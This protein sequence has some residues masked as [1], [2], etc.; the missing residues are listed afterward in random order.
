MGMLL[1][2]IVPPQI[3]FCANRFGAFGVLSPG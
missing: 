3:Y 2:L 1:H